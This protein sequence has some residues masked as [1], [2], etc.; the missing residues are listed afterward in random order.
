MDPRAAKAG[1]VLNHLATSLNQ[2]MDLLQTTV[3]MIRPPSASTLPGVTATLSGIAQATEHA[4]IQVLD[5]ADALQE[6]QRRLTVALDDLAGRLPKGDAEAAAAW[7]QASSCAK[8]LSARAMKFTAAME[9]QDLAA[10]HIGKIVASVEDVRARL[11]AVL[12]LFQ[13]PGEAGTPYV[14][15]PESEIGS[16]TRGRGEGQALADKLLADRG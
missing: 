15:L 2:M 7:D 13:A 1:Q 8:A 9:F 5:E 10:Q 4:A 6:D 11:R 3:D 12:A 16:P 14:E